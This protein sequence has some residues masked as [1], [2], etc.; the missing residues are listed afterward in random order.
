[1]KQANSDEFEEFLV[2]DVTEDL[3]EQEN[4]EVYAESTFFGGR[5]AGE[6]AWEDSV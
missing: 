2:A 3:I 5:K 6:N 4:R 1:M